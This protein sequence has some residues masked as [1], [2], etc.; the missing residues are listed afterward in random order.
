MSMR[1]PF[2]YTGTLCQRA[3][4]PPYI[5]SFLFFAWKYVSIV[6]TP[7]VGLNQ[8][9]TLQANDTGRHYILFFFKVT[10][11]TLSITFF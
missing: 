6:D 9:G 1:E 7:K 3:P 8:C 5:F 10:M 4:P 11:Y 2:S